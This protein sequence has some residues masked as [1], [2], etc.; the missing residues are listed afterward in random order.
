M[1]YYTIT[2]EQALDFWMKFLNPN[3]MPTLKQ[4]DIFHKIELL[5][6]GSFTMDSTLISERF[7]HG[8]V[9]MLLD[10]GCAARDVNRDGEKEID[11]KKLK[12]KLMRNEIDVEY[13]NQLLKTDSEF[14]LEGDD[15]DEIFG[16]TAGYKTLKF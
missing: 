14:I 2:K 15:E 1:R 4:Q 13:L 5:A 10:K 12:I 8:L 16:S 9:E 3:R 7:A 6:R 11:M